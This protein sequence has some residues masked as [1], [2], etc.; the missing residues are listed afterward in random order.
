H[1][2]RGQPTILQ[3]EPVAAHG[4][5]AHGADLELAHEGRQVVTHAL[6]RHAHVLRTPCRRDVDSEPACGHLV[7]R[8]TGA[9][10]SWHGLRFPG[11]GL[12]RR[13]CRLARTLGARG[14]RVNSFFTNDA[15]VRLCHAQRVAKGPGAPLPHALGSTEG[16]PHVLDIPPDCLGV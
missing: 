2:A 12:R 4:V 7:D 16:Y 14:R 10:D 8:S 6:S 3:P 5:R 1:A 13:E 15:W 9:I 11:G